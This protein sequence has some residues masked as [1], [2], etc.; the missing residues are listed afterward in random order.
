M[1]SCNMRSVASGNHTHEA[2]KNNVSLDEVLCNIMIGVYRS[3]LYFQPFSGY[4]VLTSS[5]QCH[6]RRT[7]KDS[8]VQSV[9]LQKGEG[10][11]ESTVC[12]VVLHGYYSNQKT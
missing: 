12:V 6:L 11:Q 7:G 8:A 9:D 10:I 2:V 5:P 1:K 4:P 3:K